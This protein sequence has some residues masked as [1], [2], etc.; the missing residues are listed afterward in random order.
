MTTNQP[1]F[2]DPLK[3]AIAM[4]D[5]GVKLGFYEPGEPTIA[6]F[7]GGIF[8]I[9]NDCFVEINLGYLY[10]RMAF[11]HREDAADEMSYF[12]HPDSLSIFEPQD[13]DMDDRGCSFFDGVWI[14]HLASEITHTKWLKAG[15]KIIQRN[16]SYFP[17]PKVMV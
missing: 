13:G 1:Y 8:T 3:A 4:R 11:C 6:E 15:Q 16:G 14:A 10:E 9:G 17:W 5:W 7:N 12:I 2:D